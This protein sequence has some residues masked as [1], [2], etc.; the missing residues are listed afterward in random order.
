MDD[1]SNA[2]NAG[3]AGQGTDA[4][5]NAGTGTAPATGGATGTGGS[6]AGTDTTTANG[7]GSDTDR[8]FPENTPVAQMTHAEQAAYWKY[9]SRKHQARAEQA[10]NERDLAE[11]RR[12]AGEFDRHQQAQMTELE[13]EQARAA[14]LQSKLDGYERAEARRA[15]ARKAGLSADDAEFVVGDT[16]EEMEQSAT[17]LKQ[18]LGTAGT[19]GHA[20]SHDQGTRGGRAGGNQSK[21]EAGMAEARKRGFVQAAAQTTNT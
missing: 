19:A 21:A 18:R 4:G 9:H 14:D 3:G 1:T 15:A 17:R 8:G 2:G 16:P 10:P 6:S 7:S 11:L 20:T 5:G 13:R 12:K